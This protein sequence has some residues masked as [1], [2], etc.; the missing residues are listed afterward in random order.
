MKKSEF[1]IKVSDQIKGMPTSEIENICLALARHISERSYDEVLDEI[2]KKNNSGHSGIE[3]ETATLLTE[4]K[5]LCAAVEDGEY[6]FSYEYDPSD[7]WWDDNGHFVDE[8]G[9]SHKIN[10]YIEDIIFYIKREQYAAAFEGFDLLLSIEC[11]DELGEDV[12][13]LRLIEED[14]IRAD[15]KTIAEYYAYTALMTLRGQDRIQEICRIAQL[16]P[17]DM[18]ISE[19]VYAE[20]FEIPDLYSFLNDWISFLMDESTVPVPPRRESLL[21][22]AVITQGGTPGL[23]TFTEKHGA[24]YPLAF[25]ELIRAYAADGQPETA[26]EVAK[27]GLAQVQGISPRRTE[28]ADLQIQAS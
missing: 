27:E 10:D 28:I 13:L 18:E 19:V 20:N 14:R 8:N 17:L 6:S 1:I 23:Q 21:V 24:K 7:E 9:L 16:F 5:N 11:C 3:K 26:I 12:N 25:I 4:I 22:N 2:A 15:A